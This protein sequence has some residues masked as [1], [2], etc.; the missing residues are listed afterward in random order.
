MKTDQLHIETPLIE[1]LALGRWGRCVSQKVWLK[2]EASQPCGSFKARGIGFACQHHVNNGCRQL[3]SSSGGN[4]GLAVASAGRQFG[5][6]VTV[7][8]PQ[9][10]SERSIQ[11]LREE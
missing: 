6:P 2:M 10:T 7:I 1:S 8:V 9:S 11:L 5:V 4:A 3:L